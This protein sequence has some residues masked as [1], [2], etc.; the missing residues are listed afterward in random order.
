VKKKVLS[1]LIGIGLF[2]VILVSLVGCALGEVDR[3][4]ASNITTSAENSDTGIDPADRKFF[5]GG[6]LANYAASESPDDLSN[7]DPA[8]RKFFTAPYLTAPVAAIDPADLKFFNG[9]YMVNYVAPG[10]LAHL[11]NIDPADR[12]F[13]SGGYVDAGSEAKLA[14]SVR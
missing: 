10:S 3:A 4:A 7:I 11:S 13:F 8:D 6:Y 12:K 5:D 1:Y 9:G 14:A 2:L